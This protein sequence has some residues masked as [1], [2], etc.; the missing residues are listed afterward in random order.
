MGV[1]LINKLLPALGVQTASVTITIVDA[2]KSVAIYLG[3]PFAMG[4]LSWLVLRRVK[5]EEWYY[6]KFA[7]WI[8]PITLAALLYTIVIMFSME[9]YQIITKPKELLLCAAPMLIYFAVM[10]LGSFFMAYFLECEYPTC[11]TIAFTAA[12]N[13]FELALA[14]AVSVFGFGSKGALATI[15]GPLSEIPIM[16]ALVHLSK[17][18]KRV[19]FKNG[20]SWSWA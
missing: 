1:A 10:F 20:K 11:A 16:L 17:T 5:G 18:F 2:L 9:G 4:V 15:A 13:N 6:G 8:S 7:K 14:V 19:C 3:I 12:S